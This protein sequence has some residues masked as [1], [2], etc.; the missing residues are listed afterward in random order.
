MCSKGEKLPQPKQLKKKGTTSVNY[1]QLWLQKSP[2]T[3]HSKLD[4][5]FEVV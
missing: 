5:I 3:R 2:I 4:A 1:G